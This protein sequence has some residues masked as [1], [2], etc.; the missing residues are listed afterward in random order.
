M[1]TAVQ[2]AARGD[3]QVPGSEVSVSNQ[4]WGWGW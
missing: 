1:A 4:L 2:T 3:W